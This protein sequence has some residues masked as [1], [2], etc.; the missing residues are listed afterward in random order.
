MVVYFCP[1]FVNNEG[2][3]V[4]V[5]VWGHSFV[6]RLSMLQGNGVFPK[7]LGLDSNKIEVLLEGE[8]V[9]SLQ[10]NACLHSKDGLLAGKD[11]V[12]IDIG[13]NDLCD[14]DLSVNQFAINLVSYAAFLVVGLQVKKVVVLQI[15]PR[16]SEPYEGYNSRV[17]EANL[18]IQASVATANLPIYFW[19]HRGVWNCQC[20][21]YMPD[22]IHLS[23]A[24]GYPKY[25]RSLRDCVIRV[26]NWDLSHGIEAK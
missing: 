3:A 1:L 18:A 21:I 11:L 25:V 9:L 8:G 24:V 2:M 7:N 20:N 22:G 23:P 15:M 19:K 5:A 4:Q 17:I 14:P 12:V 13:S 26:L 16:Q 10:R 6:R